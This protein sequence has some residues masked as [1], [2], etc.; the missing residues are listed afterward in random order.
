MK[1]LRL[2]ELRRGPV[3]GISQL[4]EM[5]GYRFST[6]RPLGR[7]FIDE[8]GLVQGLYNCYLNPANTKEFRCEVPGCR[9]ILQEY[10][11]R[12]MAVMDQDG[13]WYTLHSMAKEPAVYEALIDTNRRVIICL[14]HK[15]PAVLVAGEQPTRRK[16]PLI[17]IARGD[18][19]RRARLVKPRR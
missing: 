12:I 17:E 3:R 8:H 13:E 19:I 9:E 1:K 4:A 14:R 15:A 18:E 2:S 11:L 10:Y 5:N 7:K 16:A 6:E